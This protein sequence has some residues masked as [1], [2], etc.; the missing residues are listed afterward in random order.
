MSQQCNAAAKKA[1]AILG[2]INRIRPH[3]EY[4][5]QSQ[6]PRFKKD[7]IKLERGQG[8][9]TKIIQGFETLPYEERLRELS[10]F[11]LEKKRL[12]GDI[13]SLYKYLKA[14]H[15][16]EGQDLFLLV[17]ECRTRNNLVKLKSFLTVSEKGQWNQLPREVVGSPTLEILKKKLDSHLSGMV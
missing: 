5:V 7:A 12:R 11:S 15:K 4:Y 10:M 8:K 6:A 2:C 9:A 16:E 3:L 1:N 17:P 13:I 14:C